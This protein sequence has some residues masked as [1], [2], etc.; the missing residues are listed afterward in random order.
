MS[1][2]NFTGPSVGRL[3]DDSERMLAYAARAGKKIQPDIPE[4]IAMAREAL[5]RGEWTASLQGRLFCAQSRLANAIKPV[6]AEALDPKLMKAARK[7]ARRYFTLTLLLTAIILP[8]SMVMFVDSKL[9]ESGKALI[10]K[11][12]KIAI[13]LHE[14]LQRQRNSITSIKN[15]RGAGESGRRSTLTPTSAKQGIVP[16]ADK[17]PEIDSE[18]ALT[19]SAL[20]IKEQLQEF[21]RNNRQLYA[22]TIWLERLS[23]HGSENPYESPWMGSAPTR[24]DNLEVTLPMLLPRNWW[25]D[26]NKGDQHAQGPEH[27]IDDGMQKLAVYQDIRAMAQ[28]AEHTSDFL[29]SAIVAFV[30]PVLYAV[31]GTLAFILRDLCARTRNYTYHASHARCSNHARVIVAAIVG[32]VIGL[33]DKFM[34]SSISASPLAIAFI[35]GYAVDP[36]FALIDHIA[37]TGRTPSGIHGPTNKPE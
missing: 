6:T 29:W 2:A 1:S 32:T 28:N 21:A 3:L 34:D 7:A 5:V 22:E 12:D 25:S 19:P 9:S 15:R 37:T 4:T 36:F 23:L 24:R 26:G 30:L 20:V 16:V 31:L 35:A 14:A 17:G 13:P 18:L 8:A 11:N 10:E 33:F 27:A